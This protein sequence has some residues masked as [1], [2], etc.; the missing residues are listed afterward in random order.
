MAF[1]H[2][3]HIRSARADAVSSALSHQ[4][5]GSS[6]NARRW[7]RL[8]VLT[9]VRTVVGAMFLLYFVLDIQAR[10]R[11]LTSGD[12]GAYLLIGLIFVVTLIAAILLQT[13]NV[14]TVALWA[15]IAFDIALSTAVIVLTGSSESPFVFLYLVAIIEASIL[16]GRTGGYVAA[17][18]SWLNWLG[19][20]AF[21]A[22]GPVGPHLYQ[23]GVQAIAQVLVAFLSSYVSEQLA[24]SNEKLSESQADLDRLT[25]IHD[26]IV[27]AIPSGLVTCDREG[28]PTSVN[29][30]A[31]DI[32]GGT[33]NRT[34]LAMLSAAP[35]GRPF[36]GECETSRGTR[37]LSALR[38]PLDEAIGATLIVFQDLTEL[39]SLEREVTR[40][41]NLAS[42]GKLFAQLAH[43]VRNPLSAMRGAAQLISDVDADQRTRLAQ[44]IISES[45]RL[46]LLVGG[47]LK[48]TRPPPPK[49]VPLRLDSVVAETVEM[50]RMD[51]AYARL[52]ADLKPCP[53]IV[54]PSQIKQVILNLLRN[55]SKATEGGHGR[56]RIATSVA[57][58]APTLSVWDSAGAVRQEDAER[59]FEPMVSATA[60]GTGLGLSTVR[61]IVHAHGGQ[62]TLTSNLTEGTLFSVRFPG[63]S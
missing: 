55:A 4:S 57:D 28:R 15:H 7:P 20:S 26:Q 39:R 5:Q 32:L 60:D 3:E 49:P 19:V 45:D 33:P 61:S 48:M 23:L 47:Y 40:I 44:L 27:H 56:V 63:A 21:F 31:Y 35:V 62:I 30:A 42:L 54:D 38:V 25:A 53:A 16:L 1:V 37:T 2:R 18:V 52:D 34:Q 8:M 51:P 58:G 36:E 12:Y 59:I 9:F 46:N 11:P 13:R 10:N 24:R 22:G 43:E 14:P 41:D 29:P 50:L 6:V 17:A